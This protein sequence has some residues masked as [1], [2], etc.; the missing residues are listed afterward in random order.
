MA[1]LKTDPMI[2][3]GIKSTDQGAVMTVWAAVARELKGKGR[4]YLENC[5]TVFV[6][7]EP[8]PQDPRVAEHAFDEESEEKL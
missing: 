3:K 5:Q 1:E 7:K 6:V 8:R 2:N 4:L